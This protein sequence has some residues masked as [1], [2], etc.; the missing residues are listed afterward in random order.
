MQLG[1]PYKNVK[2]AGLPVP[3]T[4]GA[5][6]DR[7]NGRAAGE[8]VLVDPARKTVTSRWAPVALSPAPECSMKTWT[9]GGILP[10]SVTSDTGL[11][12]SGVHTSGTFAFTFTSPGTYVYFCTVHGRNVMFGSVVVH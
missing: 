4:E 2:S 8:R 9:L 1:V 7:G 12:D 10:H 5:G 6:R 11:F 3:S